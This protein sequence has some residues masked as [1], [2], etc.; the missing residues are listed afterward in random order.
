MDKKYVLVVNNHIVSTPAPLPISY[1]NI[2]NIFVLPD[3][4]LADLSWS[5]NDEG[6]WVV[7]S[8]PLPTIN[9]QQK[10]ETSYSLNIENK[11]CHESFTVVDVTPSEEEIRKNRIE[12]SIRMIR[13]QYLVITDFTQLSD[14]PIS[15]AAK[16]DFKNFRQQL[17]TMLDIPD[18]TQAVWPTIPTS[19][20][21]ISI[22]PFPPM[23]S[24]NG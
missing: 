19:A 17:R 5:G 12:T 21:N 13:D 2:S 7:N 14:S 22:P 3:D 24:F 20:P 1:K 23:P 18:I 10:I 15:D 6:F 11:T 4:K 16:L 9:I 8:D